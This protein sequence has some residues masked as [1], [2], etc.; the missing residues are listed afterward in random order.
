[1]TPSLSIPP[2]FP[3]YLKET[4]CSLHREAFER[5]SAE[6]QIVARLVTDPRMQSVWEELEKRNHDPNDRQIDGSPKT[7][8]HQVYAEPGAD[9]LEQQVAIRSFF[10]YIVEVA[11]FRIPRLPKWESGAFDKSRRRNEA[12][13]LRAGAEIL[14]KRVG[15]SV[16]LASE[17]DLCRQHQRLMDLLRSATILDHETEPS[18]EKRHKLMVKEFVGGVG[19]QAKLLFG[20]ALTKTTANIATVSFWREIT[21]NTVRE[22]FRSLSGPRWSLAKPKSRKAKSAPAAG[23][24]KKP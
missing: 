18:W 12:A 24:S 21:P 15:E 19:V 10:H 5:G 1:M 4:A 9:E 3:P 8:K 23:Y 17:D 22:I 7:F 13:T 2:W 14:R 16:R 20:S 6:G 11:A